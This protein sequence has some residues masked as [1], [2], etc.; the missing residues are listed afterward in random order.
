MDGYRIKGQDFQA[1]SQAFGKNSQT[2]LLR[3]MLHWGTHEFFQS[4]QNLIDICNGIIVA[5]QTVY[6]GPTDLIALNDTD[7]DALC[8]SMKENTHNVIDVMT[9]LL[10]LY[11]QWN[12][13]K[14][15][16]S[17]RM[18]CADISWQE[19]QGFRTYLKTVNPHTSDK[20]IDQQKTWDLMIASGSPGTVLLY[21]IIHQCFKRLTHERRQGKVRLDL[22]K[23]FDAYH[24][25]KGFCNPERAQKVFDNLIGYYGTGHWSVEPEENAFWFDK[26]EQ[27]VI[28][29]IQKIEKLPYTKE[30][31]VLYGAGHFRPIKKLLI[32]NGWHALCDPVWSTAWTFPS[33]TTQEMMKALNTITS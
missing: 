3:G 30:I 7:F 14:Y 29:L 8:Q 21:K 12:V 20:K 19:M 5:E 13:V 18:L 22:I 31:L 25:K 33:C 9:K 32:K 11:Y 4:A 15:P 6:C 27:R 10:G 17:P 28:K 24:S 2:L 16:P 1:A 26:R 23:L